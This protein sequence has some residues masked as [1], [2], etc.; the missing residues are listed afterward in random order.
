MVIIPRFFE[1]FSHEN[2]FFH[3]GCADLEII[4]LIVERYIA[5]NGYTKKGGELDGDCS[6]QRI[7]S[8][9]IFVF[10]FI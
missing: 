3:C 2:D 1:K 6:R 7:K 4:G 8:V 5:E 10:M 9:L